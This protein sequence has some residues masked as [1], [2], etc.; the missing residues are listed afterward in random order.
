MW[1]SAHILFRG[2]TVTGSNIN[3]T[4]SSISIIL[5]TTKMTEFVMCDGY[6]HDCDERSALRFGEYKYEKKNRERTHLRYWWWP[7]WNHRHMMERA[8]E[9]SAEEKPYQAMTEA[10]WFY[11]FDFPVQLQK[12]WDVEFGNVCEKILWWLTSPNRIFY[13]GNTVEMRNGMV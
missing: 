7:I 2:L 9:I 3:A 12:M 11:T 5:S 13:M 8:F 1:N 6:T 10:Y 4:G